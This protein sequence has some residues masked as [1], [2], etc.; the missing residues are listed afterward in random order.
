VKKIIS[1]VL[2]VLLSFVVASYGWAGTESV[3]YSFTGGN[4]GAYAVDSARLVRAKSGALYGTAAGGGTC[5]E[6]VV[7]SVMPKGTESVLYNFCGTDGANP[8]GSLIVDASGTLYGTTYVGGDKNCGTVFKLSGST[9]TRL[10]SFTCGQDGARPTAGVI[11][12]AK[13]NL[14][15]TTFYGGN[16]NCP[17]S[18]Y[19]CGVVYEILAS[20]EF[21]V[22]YS[23]CSSSGCSDGAEPLCDLAFDPHGNILGTTAVG[24][25]S[26]E[27]TV[28]E[29]LKPK[30]KSGW[31]ETVLHS[32][33]GSDGGVPHAGLTVVKER[34]QG[35]NSTLIFG[36]AA[37]GGSS[38]YQGDVFE[39]TPSG[40]SYTFSVIYNFTGNNGDGAQPLG[41]LTWV[42]G[43]LV[44]TTSAGGDTNCSSPFG[45]GTVFELINNNNVWTETVL[46]VFEGSDGNSP[47]GGMVVAGKRL[48]GATYV[49]GNLSRGVVFSL[50]P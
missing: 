13:G 10:Y 33:V 24:G 32:F 1:R 22:I 16:L 37:Y 49:G 18:Q 43:K 48:Y 14:Y 15:G 41:P 40:G 45:C 3:L 2:L 38:G 47:Q 42:K 20:G 26:N 12:D 4:D 11:R 9:L 35:Q 28:F 7:F 39:L 36:V 23:F 29:L 30:P 44:G 5:G 27:G 50:T 31:K 8:Y 17:Q 34:V 46:H 21:S 19:G 6:G 25:A